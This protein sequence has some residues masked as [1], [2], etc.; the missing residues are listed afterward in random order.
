MLHTA[1]RLWQISR[2]DDDYC[3]WIT[4]VDYWPC[5]RHM[6]VKIGVRVEKSHSDHEIAT[7]VSSPTLIL[8]ILASFRALLT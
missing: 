3:N 4:D 6:E 8:A 1:H 2:Y 7:C 5:M